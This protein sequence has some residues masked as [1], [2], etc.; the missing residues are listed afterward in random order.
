[1]TSEKVAPG[2]PPR[3]HMFKPGQSGNPRGRPRRSRNLATLLFNHLNEKVLFEGRKITRFESKLRSQVDNAVAG[4][5]W[6]VRQVVKHCLTFHW[7]VPDGVDWNVENKIVGETYQLLE[8]LYQV[9]RA[10]DAKRARKAAKS[11]ER[12]KAR[13]ERA[14]KKRAVA[15]V[16]RMK[17]ERGAMWEAFFAKLNITPDPTSGVTGSPQADSR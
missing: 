13:A 6:A 4:E 16:A 1:M 10:E 14:R 9:Q 17:E 12:K 8:R 2:H 11:A 7:D 3:E 15:R 5:A